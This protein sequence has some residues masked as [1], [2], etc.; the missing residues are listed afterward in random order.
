MLAACGKEP[1]PRPVRT[2]VPTGWVPQTKMPVPPMPAATPESIA[3]GKV[4]YVKM[5]CAGCH[6]YTGKGW[7]GPDLTDSYWRYGGTPDDI[8]R[9]IYE[10]R[11]QGMPAWGKALPS[12]EIWELVHYIGSL[13]THPG[14]D[15]STVG[16]NTHAGVFIDSLPPSHQPEPPK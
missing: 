14:G 3:A 13:P 15:P 16:P 12:E 6:S 7:M 2:Q 9:T 5:N 11:P 1:E 4:L 8:Y 10:G